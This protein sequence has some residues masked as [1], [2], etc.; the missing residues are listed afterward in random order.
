MMRGIDQLLF[1]AQIAVAIAGFAGI[2]VGLLSRSSHKWVAFERARFSDFLAITLGCA[3]FSIVPL[4]LASVP[5]STQ[6]IVAFCGIP[7]AL[8]F[9][10]FTARAARQ[11]RHLGEGT[12][13]YRLVQARAVFCVTLLLALL[14]TLNSIGIVFDRALWVYTM[15]LVWILV[16][17]GLRFMRIIQSAIQSS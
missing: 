10:F 3:L 7:A 13:R 11:Y 15:F 1:L 5:L 14:V 9:A 2:V 12:P 16:W 17:A 4:I 6:Q 8:Y